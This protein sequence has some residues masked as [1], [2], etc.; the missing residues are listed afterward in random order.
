[1]NVLTGSREQLEKQ[2]AGIIAKLCN[3]Y[4]LKQETVTFAVPGGTSVN[5]IFSNLLLEEIPWN[6]VHIFMV[7]EHLI[8]LA[9]EQNNFRLAQQTFL[10]F[11]VTE[12]KL[13]VQN[14]HPF[15][16]NP[17]LLDKGAEQYQHEL[18]QFSNHFDIVLL[19]SGE[20]GHIASLFPNH[21]TI[22][23]DSSFFI[24]TNTAPKSPAQRMTSSKNLIERSK[25]ALLIFFGESKRNA[26]LNFK[27]KNL[28]VEGCPAKLINMIPERYVITD[29]SD[30]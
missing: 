8:P 13:P 25:S 17:M 16:F 30:N 7:D 26:Y 15:R 9:D 4:A 20:D 29:I 3:S 27:N 5:G 28:S 22:K 10:K 2:A 1:M 14:I 19:S 12:Q 24:T 18:L 23:S 21:E 6:K 11:L